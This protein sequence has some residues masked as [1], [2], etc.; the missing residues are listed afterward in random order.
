MIKNVFGTTVDLLGEAIVSGRYAPGDVLN[1]EIDASE[2]LNVSRSAYREAIRILAAKGLVESRP[3]TGTRVL[4]R[5]RWNLLDPDVL[6]WAF[7]GEPDI[8]FVR[9]LFE[10]RSI[11]GKP[12]AGILKDTVL[13]PGYGTVDVDFTADNRTLV[14]GTSFGEIILIDPETFE[15]QTPEFKGLNGNVQ[16]GGESP[17]L[18]ARATLVILPLR[19]NS[20]RI[21]QSVAS[22]LAST[23]IK[24][25]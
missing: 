8:H 10:L 25:V 3:K 23:F 1:N 22:S 21:F 19:C 20:R 18:A 6:A 11:N 4:P 15:R 16:G 7:S 13:V 12:T 9:S 2:Q 24:P 5:N 17:T 14:C